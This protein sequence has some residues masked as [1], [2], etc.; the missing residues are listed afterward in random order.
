VPG[1]K[2][3]RASAVEERPLRARAD[4][5][6][7]TPEENLESIRLLRRRRTTLLYGGIGLIVLCALAVFLLPRKVAIVMRLAPV[8][9]T[10]VMVLLERSLMRCPR[11]G[12]RAAY[13]LPSCHVCGA[14]LEE[15]KS[16][17]P[18]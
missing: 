3:K 14:H 11:C 17:P 9:L 15:Q 8:P 6:A 4:A 18:A 10:V 13:G 5:P 7:F 2:K 12:A 1:G 16:K